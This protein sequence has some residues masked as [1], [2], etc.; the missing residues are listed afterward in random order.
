MFSPTQIPHLPG[1]PLR[2]VGLENNK[3]MYKISGFFI[4][5]GYKLIKLTKI[6]IKRQRY[7]DEFPLQA[8]SAYDLIL[9]FY[10]IP[11]SMGCLGPV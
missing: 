2:L 1:S 3:P 5:Y 11:F 6:S 9:E 7:S 4:K 10:P 8:T